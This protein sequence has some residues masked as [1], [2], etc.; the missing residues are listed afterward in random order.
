MEDIN[1]FL[2]SLNE[3][4]SSSSSYSSAP[5]APFCGDDAIVIQA[6]AK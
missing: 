4:S 3:S 1:K 2:A 5:F 6:T